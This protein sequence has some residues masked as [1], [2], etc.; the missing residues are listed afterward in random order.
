MI[1][2]H[3]NCSMVKAKKQIVVTARK[4]QSNYQT[5]ITLLN[6]LKYLLKKKK[7]VIG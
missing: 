5:S 4:K 3:G 2:M 1:F 7:K 6:S